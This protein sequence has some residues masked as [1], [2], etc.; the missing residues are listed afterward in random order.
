MPALMNS[1][2]GSLAGMIEADAIRACCLPVK[3]RRKISRMSSLFMRPSMV[4]PP[5][6]LASGF[7]RLQLHLA[8]H[9][10]DRAAADPDRAAVIGGD[11]HAALAPE[12]GALARDVGS[13]GPAA[14]QQ[15][16]GQGGVQAAGDRV[17]V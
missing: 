5:A 7:L 4:P 3:N 13:G 17:L 15:P 2:V 6:G 10:G 9:A 12:R 1:S 16:L 11:V 8:G 14:A